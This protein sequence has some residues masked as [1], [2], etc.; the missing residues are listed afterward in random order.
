MIGGLALEIKGL[1]GFETRQFSSGIST[2]N[3]KRMSQSFHM[4]EHIPLVSNT[5][6]T[7]NMEVTTSQLSY[8]NNCKYIY[9]Y[10]YIHKP[11]KLHLLVKIYCLRGERN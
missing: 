5:I 6:K 2:S 11:S 10:I 7:S 9:T 8:V 1:N 3:L 4:S